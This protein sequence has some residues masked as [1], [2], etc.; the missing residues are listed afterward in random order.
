[1]AEGAVFIAGDWGNT[2]LR[3]YRFVERADGSCRLAETR[4]GPGVLQV[5]GGCEETL[6]ERVG[7]WLEASR[8]PIILAGAVGANVGWVHA[9][10]VDCPAAPERIAEAAV[11][12][13]A[14]GQDITILPGLRT[15]NPAGYADVLRSEELQALGWLALSPENRKG[16]HLLVA[17]G[18]H[19]KW[20]LLKEGIVE[21]F[22]SS[23]TGELFA[24]LEAHSILLAQ[25]T[26]TGT[27]TADKPSAGQ[28]GESSAFDLGLAAAQD[29]KG[30]LLQAL[31]TVRSRQIASELTAAQARDYLSAL[32]IAAD[33][34]GA[35]QLLGQRLADAK[36]ITIIA[37]P[38]LAQAYQRALAQSGL[39]SALA[40]PQAIA[41][42]AFKKAHRLLHP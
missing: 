7:D 17:P 6:F 8:Q 14:R 9:P 34:E 5:P 21:T 38:P 28:D 20:M 25:P 39:K 42:A 31:F 10:Y 27:V 37:E 41:E 1:M 26:A 30:A 35:K 3:L 22:L 12:L 2:N 11:R 40:A 16:A 18:T 19:C 4:Q 15:R 23:M 13:S 32:L 36:S 29:H 33:I 24:I